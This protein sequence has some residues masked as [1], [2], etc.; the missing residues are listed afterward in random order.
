[1]HMHPPTNP[2]VFPLFIQAWRILK[3]FLTSVALERWVILA[4]RRQVMLG[5]SFGV[6]ALLCLIFALT[7]DNFF[8]RNDELFVG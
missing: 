6:P 5:V 4:T 1:M 7:V 3:M 2:Y 8:Y